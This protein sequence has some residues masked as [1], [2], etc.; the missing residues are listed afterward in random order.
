MNP[1]NLQDSVQLFLEQLS[2][3]Y[4]TVDKT[5]LII[6]KNERQYTVFLESIPEVRIER[7]EPLGYFEWHDS[8]EFV[9][10]AAYFVS[11]TPCLASAR[12]DE[13]KKC[14][15]FRKVFTAE[16]SWWSMGAQ[17]YR[18]L[19]DIDQSVEAFRDACSVDDDLYKLRLEE[20]VEL[21]LI[22]EEKNEPQDDYIYGTDRETNI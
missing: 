13:Q 21:G 10:T 16:T 19:D 8:I 14:V 18:S 22:K 11:D 6:R 5:T 12:V 20:L 15:I 3:K 1:I 7:K 2:F 17:L 4:R 9:K